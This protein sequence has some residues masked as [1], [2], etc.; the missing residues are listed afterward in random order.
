MNEILHHND[1]ASV[2]G[3]YE[4]LPY[5]YRDP[6]D[7]DT[8]LIKTILSE[9]GLVTQVAWGG[10]EPDWDNLR[11]LDAGG[12]TGDGTVYLAE[13]MRGSK[14]E[15]VYLDFTEA[16]RKVTE[17]RLARR[18]LK[19]VRC[20][21]GS[22]LALDT[23]DLGQF[24]LI[25]SSGVLHHLIDPVAGL[26]QLVKGLKPGGLIGLM[27]YGKHGRNAI[28]PLQDLLRRVVS[29]HLPMAE[30]VRL[31]RLVLA[32]LKPTHPFNA[33]GIRQRFELS[34]RD[35]TEFYDLFLH[36]QDRAYSVPELY[37]WVNAAGGA[38][39]E[40]VGVGLPGNDYDPASVWGRNPELMGLVKD[41][42]LAEQAAVAELA[43]F[44]M[45]KHNF[46]IHRQGDS[47]KALGF[48]DPNAIAAMTFEHK[49]TLDGICKVLREGGAKPGMTLTSDTTYAP[50]LLQVG[51]LTAKAV[52]LWDGA[53]TR[54]E[55][56]AK[57]VKGGANEAEAKAEVAR[58]LEGFRRGGNVFVRQVAARY[59]RLAKNAGV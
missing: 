32:N 22:I 8:R 49:K 30:Q 53:S 24:D 45:H 26:A 10:R 38:M 51:P 4:G 58:M 57:L 48:D 14:G 43:G 18:G 9:L 50:A 37:D 5:P 36:S 42:P 46:F 25:V 34:G 1:R 29:A 33:P 59:G 39:L 17:A 44:E 13:Q 12:G 47:L 7:E 3:Q 35:D 2:K 40:P 23:L 27:V 11:V 56:V 52:P 54:A 6:A 16:S 28:Y 15:V 20:V 41:L 31:A 55:M 19:N 21:T